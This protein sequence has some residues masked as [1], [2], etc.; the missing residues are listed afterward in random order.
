VDEVLAV[1][2]GELFG[3]VVFDFGEDEGG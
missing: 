2:E 1:G 3:L